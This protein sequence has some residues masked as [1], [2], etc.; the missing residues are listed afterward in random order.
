MEYHSKYGTEIILRVHRKD[1]ERARIEPAMNFASRTAPN[2][3]QFDRWLAKGAVR[4]WLYESKVDGGRG[5][6]VG[7]F[8]CP[9]IARAT[10][11]RARGPRLSDGT[12]FVG[13]DFCLWRVR[14]LHLFAAAQPRER[15]GLACPPDSW[16]RV[17]CKKEGGNDAEG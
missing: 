6:I 12:Y 10:A 5:A 8:D 2:K 16:V 14:D 3:A 4:V 11:W 13:K 7:C 15:F 9:G 1:I 17:L